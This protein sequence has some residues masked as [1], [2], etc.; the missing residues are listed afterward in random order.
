MKQ[1]FILFFLCL[2]AVG[3]QAQEDAEAG[4]TIFAT[5]CASCHNFKQEMTGPAL[6]D[7]HTRRKAEWIVKFVQSSQTVIE[8]GDPDAKAVFAKYQ[9]VMPDHRDLKEADVLNIIAFIKAES[10]RITLEAANNPIKRPKEVGTTDRPMIWAKDWWKFVIY[11]LL[12]S[13]AIYAMQ[14]AINANELR[15]KMEDKE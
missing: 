4:K 6:K 9:T 2:A 1:L 14:L 7:V 12:L 5:R 15:K 3:L 13:M 8:S 11:G 10:A